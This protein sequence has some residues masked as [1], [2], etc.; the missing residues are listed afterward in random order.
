MD[1]KLI[2]IIERSIE[3]FLDSGIRNVSMDDIASSQSIS[4][5]TL[6]KYVKNKKDLLEKTFDYHSSIIRQQIEEV[7]NGNHNAIEVL[8]EISMIMEGQIR[9]FDPK[10]KFEMRKY[11]PELLHENLNKHIKNVYQQMTL[12]L[13]QGMKEGLYRSD[14][15]IALTAEFYMKQLTNMHNLSNC[16]LEHFSFETIF[17]VMFEN[18]IRSIANSK[19]IKKFEE[20]KE[21]YKLNQHNKNE[22]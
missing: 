14:L 12:N 8:L 6:Y 1:Q 9:R 17:T 19:G 5:K 22:K 16:K 13:E 15:N 10:L 11:Y 20:I 18:H 7:I 21:R 2:S 3:L 4:K